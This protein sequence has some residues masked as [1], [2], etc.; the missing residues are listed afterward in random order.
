VIELFQLHDNFREKSCIN[1]V[2][3]ENVM[4]STAKA[5]LGSNL[6]FR[7]CDGPVGKKIFGVGVQYLEEME[8]IVL[9]VSKKLFNAGYVEHRLLSGTMACSAIQYALTQAT[10]KYKI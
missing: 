10:S 9:E 6:G 2:A 8:A 1:L 3:S 7:V 4:S 5:F